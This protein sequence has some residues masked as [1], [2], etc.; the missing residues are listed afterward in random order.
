MSPLSVRWLVGCL[1]FNGPLR[2]Y[3]SLTVRTSV[4]YVCP[5]QTGFCLLCFEKL[6]VLDS[7]FTLV[8]YYNLQV[9]FDLG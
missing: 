7:F 5:V 2:Q 3:F 1:G 4:T 6:M 8:Y 9:K